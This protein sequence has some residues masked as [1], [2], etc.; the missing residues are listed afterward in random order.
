MPSPSVIHRFLLLSS[1]LVTIGTLLIGS[2]V[3][4]HEIRQ[5]H[6]Q[7][8]EYNVVLTRIA[9][10]LIQPWQPGTTLNPDEIDLRLAQLLQQPNIAK[11][12][13]YDLEGTTLYST[14]RSQIG[15]SKRDNPALIAARHG[16]V[17]SEITHRNQFSASE[18]KRF[19]VDLVSSYIP[20][21]RTWPD[22]RR[23]RALSGRHSARKPA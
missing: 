4:E 16:Q 5:I 7:A 22:H 14:D 19:D 6:L 18:G 12:K 15:E 10:Q 8:E 20:P 23:F 1:V 2:L 3:R 11:I 21:T 17:S 9:G 13:L